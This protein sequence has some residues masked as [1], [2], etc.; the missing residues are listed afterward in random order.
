VHYDELAPMLLNVVQK[1]ERRAA[2]QAEQIRV[3]Q[4]AVVALQASHQNH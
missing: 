2:E 4:A 3:L 1:Q